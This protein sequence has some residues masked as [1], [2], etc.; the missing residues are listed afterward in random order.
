MSASSYRPPQKQALGSTRSGLSRPNPSF[1]RTRYGKRRKAGLRH[2]VH[3]REV[4][5]AYSACLRGPVNS[6]VRPHWEKPSDSLKLRLKLL[7]G[8]T[9]DRWRVQNAKIGKAAR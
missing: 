5:R 9:T 8:A 1:N 2:M 6:N 7:V 4:S 3:H